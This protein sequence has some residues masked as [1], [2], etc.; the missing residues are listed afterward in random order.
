MYPEGKAGSEGGKK[1]GKPFSFGG[2]FNIER[3]SEEKKRR[4]FCMGLFSL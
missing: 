2:I 4:L 3:V 1:G